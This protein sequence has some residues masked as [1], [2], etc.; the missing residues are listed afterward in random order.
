[1]TS[2]GSVPTRT[3]VSATEAERTDRLVGA[4]VEAFGAPPDGVWASSGR[5]NLMGEHTDY[6]DGFVLPFAL[7]RSTLAAVRRRDDDVVRVATTGPYDPVETTV[8]AIAPGTDL[9]WAG[10]PLGTLW[11]LRDDGHAVPGLDIVLDSTVPTGAGLSSSA[12]LSCSIALAVDELAGLGLDRKAL[13]AAARRAENEVVGS[14]TGPMDQLASLLGEPDAAILIDCRSIDV[15]PVPFDLD[16]AGLTLLVIDTHAT[17]ELN[18]GGYAS[19]HQSCIEAAQALGV[20]ALRD[21]T[22]EQVEAA[23]ERLGDETFRR[24]RHVVTEDQR[25][26]DLVELLEVGRIREAGPLFAASH[27]SMRDDFEISVPELDAAV[28]AALAGGALGARMTGGGF[29]G[30]AIALVPVDAVDAV[31]ASVAARYR[32]EGFPAAD[33]FAVR[34]AA[35]AHRVR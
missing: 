21:A 35:G 10:Y 18:D 30:S 32:Q 8:G 6:N 28:E 12:A 3:D 14:P 7:D 2:D 27:A 33:V 22:L 17:H 13:A 5:V 1:M 26:L 29:G 11:S 31:S 15:R 20:D 34:P 24:A 9:D 4:F 16:R 19:R 25:V 23:R